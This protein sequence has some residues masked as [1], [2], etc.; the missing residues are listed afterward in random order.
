MSTPETKSKEKLCTLADGKAEYAREHAAAI[1]DDIPLPTIY[2]INLESSTERRAAMEARFKL[3]GVVPVFVKAVTGNCG[4][5]Q[6]YRKDHHVVEQYPPGTCDRDKTGAVPPGNFG[7]SASHF[8]AIRLFLETKDKEAIICEDDIVFHKNFR[9]LYTAAYRNIPEKT[10]LLS[11]GYIQIGW[12]NVKW[13]GKD[14]ALQNIATISPYNTYGTQ[15]YLVT[16]EYA[17]KIL[18]DYD[19]PWYWYPQLGICEMYVRDSG[20]YLQFPPLAIETAT[21]SDRHG[22]AN[23]MDYWDMW[24]RD[25]YVH[26]SITKL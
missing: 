13:A 26:E 15:M 3:L 8:K 2:C 23:V 22:Q 21:I 11:L 25:N 5:A 24:G 19:K 7:C 12:K 16:R 14:I 1:T 18:Q 9:Q 10:S 20:G 4:L 17:I 6:F